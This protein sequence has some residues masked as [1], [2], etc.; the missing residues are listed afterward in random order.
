MTA[1]K[2]VLPYLINKRRQAEL[3]LEFQAT[4]RKG[5]EKVPAE[6]HARREEIHK[7]LRA[8][9]ARRNR[10]DAERLSEEAP[11]RGRPRTDDAI[12]RTHGKQNHEKPAETTG[13]IQ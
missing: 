12:V 6:V 7:E 2:L 10:L 1:L 13:S 11:R 9:N 4:K 5:W 8:L 3:A